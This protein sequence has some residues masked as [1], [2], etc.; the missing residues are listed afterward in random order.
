MPHFQWICK[1]NL[2]WF[3]DSYNLSNSIFLYYVYKM[4]PKHILLVPFH[5][6]VCDLFVLS[7]LG[8]STKIKQQFPLPSSLCALWF[9]LC[10]PVLAV[11]WREHSWV[12]LTMESHRRGKM[13]LH[14]L[15]QRNHQTSFPVML[16]KTHSQHFREIQLPILP[17]HMT[18]TNRI[19][20]ERERGNG[21]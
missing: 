11:L 9:E 5:F 10:R 17:L 13:E 1:K 12:D 21:V 15:D 20:N 4:T 16:I 18:M 2:L 8:E 14:S 7:S 6:W 3:R 19:R